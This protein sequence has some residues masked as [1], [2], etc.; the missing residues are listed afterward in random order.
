MIQ[1]IQVL[2]FLLLFPLALFSGI[3]VLLYSGAGCQNLN[4]IIYNTG[5]CEILS[6]NSSSKY[7]CNTTSV[8]VNTYSSSDCSGPV[9]ESVTAYDQL[10]TCIRS[11]IGSTTVLCNYNPPA[12]GIIMSS[13]FYSNPTCQGPPSMATY[14]TESCLAQ[15]SISAKYFCSNNVLVANI[16]SNTTTCSGTPSSIMNTS[17]VSGC[18][19]ITMEGYQQ[20]CGFVAAA[21]RSDV[22]NSATI[23]FFAVVY[24]I[25]IFIH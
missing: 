4:S 13:L 17:L 7:S 9:S 19:N 11:I 20:F 25:V 14:L 15:N 6:A 24:L 2:V 18:T 5:S 16:Y 3:G 22:M 12:N 21:T 10:N 8:T 1:K 23:W